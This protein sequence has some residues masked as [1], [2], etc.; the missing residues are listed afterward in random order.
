MEQGMEH[1]LYCLW[2]SDPFFKSEHG[3]YDR[4]ITWETGDRLLI[5]E[6]DIVVH[7]ILIYDIDSVY[8]NPQELSL[9]DCAILARCCAKIK[10]IKNE[11]SV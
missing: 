4:I 10:L 9:D 3:D 2:N 8:A 7:D 11:S 1:F 5:Y 6:D